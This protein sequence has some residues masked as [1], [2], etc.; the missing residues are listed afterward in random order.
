MEMTVCDIIDNND[1]L[2]IILDL[3]NCSSITF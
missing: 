3:D 1:F 2:S